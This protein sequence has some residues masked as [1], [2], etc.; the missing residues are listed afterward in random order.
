MSDMEET[1]E[2]RR[3]QP[4][5]HSPVDVPFCLVCQESGAECTAF[6]PKC[7]GCQDILTSPS[8][9]VAEY[10]AILR[11]W[12]PQVQQSLEIIIRQVETPSC[13]FVALEFESQTTA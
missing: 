9:S 8:T 5:I 10:F 12:T 3:L 11:Q 4:M 2:I 7:A 6:N 1:F 13:C